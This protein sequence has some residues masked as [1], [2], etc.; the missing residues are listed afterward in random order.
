MGISSVCGRKNGYVQ[1]L[2][3]TPVQEIQWSD[4]KKL[5]TWSRYEG[6]SR[7]GLLECLG[8][9]RPIISNRWASARRGPG[10]C[11]G[12]LDRSGSTCW[13]GR[14][15]VA[16]QHFLHWSWL[17]AMHSSRVYFEF[18]VTTTRTTSFGLCLFK[19]AGALSI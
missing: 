12:A 14:F 10:S 4:G 8:T 19:N 15:H 1:D 3:I 16:C 18:F 11:R 5:Q 13:R 7:F 2:R 9:A 17:P 6:M